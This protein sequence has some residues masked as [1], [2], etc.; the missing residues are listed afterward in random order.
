MSHAGTYRLKQP[1]DSRATACQQLQALQRQQL[2]H[3][4]SST[5]EE[6]PDLTFCSLA[7]PE[8]LV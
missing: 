1:H 6:F 3:T 8:L 7:K 4:S 2:H 5:L